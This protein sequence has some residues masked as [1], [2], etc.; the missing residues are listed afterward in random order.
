MDIAELMQITIT[1]V[2]KQPQNLSDAA[3]AVFVITQDDLHRSGVTSIPEALRMVPGLQV[4]R[5]DANKWA[6]TSRGFGGTFANKLLVMIDGRTVYSPTFSGVYWDA[7]DTLLDDIDRIEVIRGPGATIWGANAV[8]GVINILTKKASE[9]QGGLVTVGGGSHDQFIGE[10][11]YGAEVGK[12]G[13]GRAYLSYH[14]QDS[15][16]LYGGEVDANDDWDSLRTGFRLDG[17][18]EDKDTWTLQGDLYSNKE[19]Q[20]LFPLRLP[21]YPYVTSEQESFDASGWNILGRWQKNLSSTSS[22]T[23]QAYYDYTN[24]D[25]TVM[26]QTH[27]TFDLDL[28]YQTRLGKRNNLVMGLG[29][30][31]VNG[32]FDNTFQASVIPDHRSENLYSG[33]LQDEIMLVT[34]QLYLTL[35]TKW[36]HNDFTGNEIQPSGRLLWKMTDVQTVWG[37]VSRAARTPSEF[38]QDGQI[39]LGVIPSLDT[40][41]MLVTMIGSHQFDSEEV[42]AYEAGYRWLPTSNLSLDMAIFYNDYDDLQ[43]VIF[44]APGAY[45]TFTFANIRYGSTYGMELSSDWKPVDWM[46]LQLGYTYIDFDLRVEGDTFGLNADDAIAGKSPKHQISFRSAINLNNDLQLNLWLRYVDQL[47]AFN[48]GVTSEEVPVDEY[49]TLDVNV[50]WRPLEN[51]ELMLVGQNLLNSSQLEYISEFSTPPTEIERS[52]YAKVTYSY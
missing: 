17:E 48:D 51:V 34:D 38:E 42:I 18:H 8:N 36:E 15:Y 32:D 37:A 2:A 10:M 40:E 49:L 5:V 41:P 52:V 45:N 43:G 19:N 22:S 11:R 30:R 25:E 1:S 23:I 14:K 3:A 26:E 20:T 29:Y 12:L 35:G 44:A 21:E 28:N 4:A 33:F 9:T 47:K 13:H 39:T 6:I 27:G 7:Q 31:S 16:E 24:R 46:K 50:S